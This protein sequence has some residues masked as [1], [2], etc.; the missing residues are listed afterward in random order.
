MQPYAVIMTNITSSQITRVYIDYDLV[1][2]HA[3]ADVS[4]CDIFRLYA[5]IVMHYFAAL[6]YLSVTRMA[7]FWHLCY[8]IY[9]IHPY[10]KCR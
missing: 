5:V 1:S 9:K 10:G 3:R 2:A 7:G 4:F 6:L 8:Q